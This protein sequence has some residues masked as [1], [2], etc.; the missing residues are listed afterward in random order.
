MF[1][2]FQ[3][4]MVALATSPGIPAA[5]DALKEGYDLYKNDHGNTPPSSICDLEELE[6]C[7]RHS[8]CIERLLEY[9]E[10]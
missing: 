5:E 2:W 9:L 1:A 10:G 3:M 4:S 8:Q 6:L 7:N